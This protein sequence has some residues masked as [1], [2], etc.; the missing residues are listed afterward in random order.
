MC[1]HCR[2][3]TVNFGTMLQQPASKETPK[4]AV[5]MILSE[6]MNVVDT[7]I[8]LPPPSTTLSLPPSSGDIKRISGL[9]IKVLKEAGMPSTI[10]ATKHLFDAV[11]GNI[12]DE[13]KE[14]VSGGGFNE[15]QTFVLSRVQS[16]L[17]VCQAKI[18]HKVGEY[19]AKYHQN[20]KTVT[21]PTSAAVGMGGDVGE[22]DWNQF[23]TTIM[24]SSTSSKNVITPQSLLEKYIQHNQQVFE[25]IDRKFAENGT[26]PNG[27]DIDCDHSFGKFLF[28]IQ[29]NTLAMVS[30]VAICDAVLE[31]FMKR[32]NS[33]SDVE[34]CKQLMDTALYNYYVGNLNRFGTK[35]Y[36][37]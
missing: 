32:G 35:Y 4:Q 31:R 29:T 7:F 18:A 28:P 9:A 5:D 14:S 37:F 25:F 13:N 23:D 12:F 22:L 19:Q 17:T 3:T 10:S 8:P 11:I 24:R 6:T 16:N 21:A 34:G 36:H 15:F 20:H 26:N 30:F 27:D 2:Q 33:N 1:V